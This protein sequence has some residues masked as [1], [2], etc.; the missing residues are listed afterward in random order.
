MLAMQTTFVHLHLHSEYSLIDGIVKIESLVQS[1]VNQ[2]MPAVAITD[3][4]NL[5]ALVKFYKAALASGIKPIVGVEVLLH[6][7]GIA[8]PTS[9]VLLA[10]NRLGHLHLSELVSKAYLEGQAQGFPMVDPQ[11]LVQHQRV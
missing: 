7:P 9:L 10:Q 4:N 3:Q 5:F 1:V 2:N 8:Q 6:C 11:W